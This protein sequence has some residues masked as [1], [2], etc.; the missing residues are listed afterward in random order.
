MLRQAK[1][2]LTRSAEGKPEDAVAHV[3]AENRVSAP[4][5]LCDHTADSSTNLSLSRTQNHGDQLVV[6]G[7]QLVL[8]GNTW[9]SIHGYQLDING[10]QLVI[11]SYQ[12]K[13]T[14]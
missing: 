13:Y 11:H 4:T 12:L 8:H 7:N 14:C 5:T 9:L 6:H 10:N 2:I 1:K 3:G